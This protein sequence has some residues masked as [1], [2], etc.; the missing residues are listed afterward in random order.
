MTKTLLRK[1][2]RLA[3]RTGANVQKGQYVVVRASVEMYEFAGMVVEE[4]YKAGAKEVRVDWRYSYTTKMA[5]R[6]QS[7]KTLC[8]V[9][10]WQEAKQAFDCKTLPA[11]INIISDG[12][13]ALKGVNGEK[14]Q[15]SSVATHKKLKKYID[16]MD[17]NYQW[18]IVAAA[19]KDWA[20]K[21]FPG[22]RTST[23]VEKLW[24]TI[25][26]TVYITDASSDPE[27]TPRETTFSGDPEKAWADHNADFMD[28][29]A[30]L[31]DAKFDYLE[32][33]SA[34]GTDF[35]CWL[36]NNILWLG[37]GETTKGVYYNPNMPT[38]EIFTTPIAG[39]CEGTLVST[40]PLSVRGN[41]VENFTFTFEDGKV[42][43]VTAEKGEDV[44]KQLIASDEGAKMLGEL[45][46]VPHNSP[47][48][49]SGILFYNTLFDENAACHVAIGRGFGNL[50]VGYENMTREQL[51]E[52]GVNESMIHVDFMIGCEDLSIVGYKDGKATPIFTNGNWDEEFVK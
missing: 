38:E 2:A 46:L 22:E 34:N 31:N 51:K 16:E 39:K 5:Y 11:Y 4:A 47:I 49:N 25:L 18:T 23:A 8:N 44:L 24:K 1:Y 45:A 52:Q 35:R 20:K 37:G 9:H 27:K 12:P 7:L 3:V 43:K 42:T 21:V 13:D 36:N 48:S 50:V 17:N 29:C 40:K 15:K 26:S 19:G 41:L 14:M 30:R 32:Y 6:H 10:D 33:K 28:K